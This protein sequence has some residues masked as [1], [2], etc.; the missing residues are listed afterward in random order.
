MYA[1]NILE[2]EVS[3]GVWKPYLAPL[4]GKKEGDAVMK[5]LLHLIEISEKYI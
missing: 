1:P 2:Q 5:S 4:C 3:K